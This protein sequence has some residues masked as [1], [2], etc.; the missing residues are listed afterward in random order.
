MLL[1]W[2]IHLPGIGSVYFLPDAGAFFDY[3][4]DLVETLMEFPRALW[5]IKSPFL[6][7]PNIH[8]V[9][10][11]LYITMPSKAKLL[12]IFKAARLDFCLT[13]HIIAQAFAATSDSMCFGRLDQCLGV[14]SEHWRWYLPGT[15]KH[16]QVGRH[17]NRWSIIQTYQHRIYFIVHQHI[18][19]PCLLSHLM[20]L[21]H[22]IQ[23]WQLL[24]PATKYS[25]VSHLL[26]QS[27]SPFQVLGKWFI[28]MM[29]TKHLV[30][31]VQ[32]FTSRWWW[33]KKML[34]LKKSSESKIFTFHVEIPVLFHYRPW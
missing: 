15:V 16:G 3:Q 10:K 27:F 20:M 12:V 9:L 32:M 13:A 19:G 5:K 11:C 33:K 18:T 4:I 29:V 28:R 22:K 6:T 1:C 31:E 8:P 34:A 14:K 24:S 17:R 2:K 26:N 23:Y 30:L 21:K 25:S 7:S